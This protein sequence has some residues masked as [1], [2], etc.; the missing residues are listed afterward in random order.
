MIAP[1]PSNTRETINDIINE[2][3]RPVSFYVVDTISACPLCSLDPITDTSTDSYCPECSGVYWIYTYSGW[4][5]TAHVTWGKSENRAWETGGMIDNGDCT[6]K[7]IY[8][9]GYENIVHSSQ[10]VMVDNRRMNVEKIILRGVPSVNRI[11]VSL[12]EEEKDG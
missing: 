5:V 8:S 11:I 6:V 9:G 10:Y 3:G 2:D 4:D 1:F 12:R 7:F